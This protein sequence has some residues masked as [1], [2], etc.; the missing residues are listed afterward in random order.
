MTNEN[1]EQT[2]YIRLKQLIQR[3][4]QDCP[5][6]REQ[7]FASIAPHTI[8]EA[9]EVSDAIERNDMPA[10]KEELGDLLFQ[11]IFHAKMAEEVGAFDLDD[12]CETLVDKMQRRHP[13]LFGGSG[14]TQADWESLKAAERLQKNQVSLLEGIALALPALSRAEKLQKRVARLGFDWPDIHGVI[15]KIIEEVEEVRESI[16]SEQAH[17]LEE[18]G[19]LLFTIINLARWMNVDPELALRQSNQKFSDRFQIIEQKAQTRALDLSD[20][21]LT[22]MQALWCEAKQALK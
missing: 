18:I 11:V 6:D 21:T 4:R 2:P 12:V 3:L 10:L 1:H 19:D 9:Y 17:R 22:D 15:D 20:M 14:T 16:S 7:T 8:E 13:Q 5:W